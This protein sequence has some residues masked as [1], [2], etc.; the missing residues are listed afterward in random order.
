[1]CFD[2]HL[3]FNCLCPPG[4]S[5]DRCE[6]DVDACS[7]DFLLTDRKFLNITR[8]CENGGLCIDG[9]GEEYSCRCGRGYTGSRCE[10]KVDYCVSDPCL[11]G[12]RCESVQGTFSCLCPY[13]K[14]NFGLKL[15]KIFF[16]FTFRMV[17]PSL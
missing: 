17:G 10:V 4:Y 5:G 6:V 3:G 7:E 12:G 16:I 8:H 9:P 11:N 1:M 13:G 14:S 15:I 2:R